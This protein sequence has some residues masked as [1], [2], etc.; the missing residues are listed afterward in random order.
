M[1]TA[2]L[3]APT[4]ELV[5]HV[6]QIVDAK[7]D[8][9][10]R[11]L[12]ELTNTSAC[13]GRM[14]DDIANGAAIPAVGNVPALPALI[15]STITLAAT[16]IAMA[17]P[18]FAAPANVVPAAAIPAVA[19]VAVP[20]VVAPPNAVAGIAVVAPVDTAPATIVI[21][22]ST[23]ADPAAVAASLIARATA[24]EKGK[25]RAPP[26]DSPD[27]LPAPKYR[28]LNTQQSSAV[29][30]PPVS[31]YGVDADSSSGLH[32]AL[33][34]AGPSR[35]GDQQQII[36]QA[37]DLRHGS[38]N[39]LYD[40]SG[41][42][43]T[44]EHLFSV[45]DPFCIVSLDF[46][47]SSYRQTRHSELK[48]SSVKPHDFTRTLARTEGLKQWSPESLGIDSTSLTSLNLLG[49]S[50][51]QLKEWRLIV[52]QRL[53]LTERSS[54]VILSPLMCYVLVTLVGMR[55]DQMTG[56]V[57]SNQFTA[58]TGE[59]LES[60]QVITRNG[61]KRMTPSDICHMAKN[62]VRK[63]SKYF[64]KN[65][66]VEHSLDMMTCCNNEYARRC[67]AA[68]DGSCVDPEGLTAIKMLKSNTYFSLLFLGIRESELVAIHKSLPYLVGKDTLVHAVHT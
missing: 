51:N 56:L 49:R 13:L 16:A 26:E 30:Q 22:G 19:A 55:A 27:T 7:I 50:D 1:D 58:I 68:G 25:G 6:K 44:V 41:E 59:H 10:R 11:E 67:R 31:E 47:L 45:I 3:G 43:V 9:K 64:S 66:N 2:G 40:C 48:P 28:L 37:N 17:V 29:V 36:G 35:L 18:V 61:T 54:A 62:W 53:G 8:E 65:P 24:A 42:E 15:D 57:R 63:L 46:L 52:L 20:S 5:V 4:H 38:S 21:S 39:T 32:C 23:D 12:N 14:A 34:S 60:L 33:P